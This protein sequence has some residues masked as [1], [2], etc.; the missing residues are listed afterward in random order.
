MEEKKA[1]KQNL[2][3]ADVR[4]GEVYYRY[5]LELAREHPGA[6]VEY[7]QLAARAKKDFPDDEWVKGATAIGIGRRLLVIEMF[8]TRHELPNLACLVVNKKGEPGSSYRRNWEEDKRLVAAFDWQSCEHDWVMHIDALRKA[9]LKPAK[10]VRRTRPEAEKLFTE[11]W[12]ADA[13]SESPQYPAHIDNKP[14]EAIIRAI[15]RGY[16]PEE[17]FRIGMSNG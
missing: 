2:T 13:A 10:R 1:R 7:G 12:N 8:C 16:A 5:L 11:H 14:K 6:A 17:G 15:E 4:L 9:T 3:A